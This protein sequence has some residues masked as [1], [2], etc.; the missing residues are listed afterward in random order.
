MS[1]CISCWTKKRFS[2]FQVMWL[3]TQGPEGTNPPGYRTIVPLLKFRIPNKLY[4][5][6][7][8]K[9]VDT[10]RIDI[11]WYVLMEGIWWSPVEG[12]V[13]LS[14]WFRLGEKSTIPNGGW[15]WGFYFTINGI[16][17]E[18]WYLIGMLVK[19]PS[20]HTKPQDCRWFLDV[21]FRER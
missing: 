16:A 13:V 15:E 20:C 1:R 21:S 12:K 4:H 19:G 8:L 6:G 2:R 7:K 11:Q 3:W 17:P 9:G 5:L 14:H 18:V 10:P